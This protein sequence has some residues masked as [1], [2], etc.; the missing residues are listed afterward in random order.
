[1]MLGVV[2]GSYTSENFALSL[3]CS[4]SSIEEVAMGWAHIAEVRNA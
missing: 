4:G 3:Y 1:M 2:E